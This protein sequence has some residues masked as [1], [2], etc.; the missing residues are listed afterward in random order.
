MIINQLIEG[1]GALVFSI[2]QFPWPKCSHYDCGITEC[3]AGP[4]L[5]SSGNQMMEKEVEATRQTDQWMDGVRLR[6]LR[7]VDH[8]S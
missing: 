1:R 6:T 4:E 7:D 8:F 5:N 3:V 2:F